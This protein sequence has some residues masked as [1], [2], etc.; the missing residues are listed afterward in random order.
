[1]KLYYYC[2]KRNV[3][4]NK[5]QNCYYTS[6]FN[7][8]SS[9]HHLAR[10][11]DGCILNTE[12]LSFFWIC[13]SHSKCNASDF[14]LWEPQHMQS[15][16]TLFDRANAQL[17]NSIFRHNHH[18]NLCIFCQ[19]WRSATETSPFQEFQWVKVMHHNYYH[20]RVPLAQ[21]DCELWMLL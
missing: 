7:S 5:T 13:N 14:F 21:A 15:E 4:L 16:I 18:H 8:P 17:Q 9:F 12:F 11:G 6:D 19:P 2:L 3:K 1:M 10:S 20:R